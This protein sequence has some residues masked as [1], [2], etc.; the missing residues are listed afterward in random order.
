[1]TGPVFVYYELNNF[2][3]NHRRYVR[4]RSDEQLLGNLLS[5]ADVESDCDPLIY[6]DIPSSMNKS[7][8]LH[9]CGLIANSYFNDTFMLADARNDNNNNELASIRSAWTEKDISWETDRLY[10]FKDVPMSERAAKRDEY[11]FLDETYPGVDNV[12][13]EHF[14]VWMRTAALP[15]FRKLYAR[16]ETDIPEDTR[17]VFNVSTNF[18]VQS[19]K[20]S[21]TL[22]VS[23]ISWLGGKNDFLGIAYIVVGAVC[24][25]LALAF[26]IKERIC[27][28]RPGEVK[29]LRW[30]SR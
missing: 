7:R 19:F 3:Q 5:A 8:V 24:A 6:G 14:I 17:L 22:V 1:M 16:I 29:Y 23:T 12:T 4:S 20:G 11:Q 21:K 26:V 2:Y 9:P 10:K 13:N 15:R 27:P 28:R 25:V 30:A 18:P